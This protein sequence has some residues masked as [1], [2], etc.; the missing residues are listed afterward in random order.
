MRAVIVHLKDASEAEVARLLSQNYVQQEGGPWLC[1]T[2]GNVCLYIQFYY[3]VRIEEG[4]EGFER[5][6]RDLGFTPAVSV[7]A[8]V[9][10][11]HPGDE[12]VRSLVSTILQRYEGRAVDEFSDHCWTLQEVISGQLVQGHSFFDYLDSH[13]A[14]NK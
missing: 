3:D 14:T 5:L 4:S 1:K 2:A 13:R 6:V 11:R 9:S 7:I 12:E 10:G 8:N